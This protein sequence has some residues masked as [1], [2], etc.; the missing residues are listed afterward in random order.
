[1]LQIAKYFYRSSVL[2][3]A[4]GVLCLVLGLRGV[5]RFVEDIGIWDTM[6]VRQFAVSVL[7]PHVLLLAGLCCLVFGI[8]MLVRGI[9]FN[10]E[11]AE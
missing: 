11:H 1:M 2:L 7:L 4:G 3:I 10:R 5:M 8:V 9:L 6:T